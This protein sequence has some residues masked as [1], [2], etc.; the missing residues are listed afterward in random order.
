M[1]SS[2][3]CKEGDSSG[4]YFQLFFNAKYDVNKISAVSSCEQR[5]AKEPLPEPR[6]THRYPTIQSHTASLESDR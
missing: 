3:V 1:K 4:T 5:R 2:G 6:V